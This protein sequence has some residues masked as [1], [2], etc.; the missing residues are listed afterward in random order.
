VSPSGRAP[1]GRGMAVPAAVLLAG[2]WRVETIGGEAGWRSLYQAGTPYIVMAWHEALLP[3]IWHHRGRGIAAIV[4]EA[5]DGQY[6]AAFARR[7]GYAIIPGSS[8]RGGTRALRAAVRTLQAGVSV[9]LT[10]DGPRGPRREL[11]PGVIIAAQRGGGTIVPVHAEAR[12]TWRLGSWDRMQV[13]SPFARIRIAYGEPFR[14][15][16]G[17]HARREA[18]AR[19][20]SALEEVTRLCAWP[21]GGATPIA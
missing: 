3:I 21:D 2:S 6:L 8:T 17:E 13:P 14:V 9:G 5:R 7:L 12:P 18:E 1:F 15:G 16:P 11:K 19:A 10:P 4:S 20:R